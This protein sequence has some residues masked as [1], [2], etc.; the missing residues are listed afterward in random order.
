LDKLHITEE[1]H[2]FA[3]VH[4]VPNQLKP[5]FEEVFK[6]VIGQ[7][8]D[9]RDDFHGGAALPHDDSSKKLLAEIKQM[10]PQ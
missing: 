7:L 5:A 9:L 2:K 6:S 3:N 4:K 10:R 8:I 1:S